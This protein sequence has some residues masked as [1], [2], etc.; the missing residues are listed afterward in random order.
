[1]TFDL[2][3]Q[4]SFGFKEESQHS[5]GLIPECLSMPDAEVI[6]YSHF[7]EKDESDLLFKKLSEEIKWRQDKITY[8]GKVIDL[9]RLTAWYGD[10]DKSY[11]YSNI[12]M[13]SDPWTPTLMY[14]KNKIEEV[15]K[16]NFNSV[17]LNL[18]RNGKDGVSWHQDN[19]PEL[20]K[21]PVIGSVS[22]GGTRR[23]QFRHKLRR[24]L[25]KI[26]VDLTHGSLLIMK[27]ETQRYWQH[28]IPKTSKPVE[29]RINLTFRVI[30]EAIKSK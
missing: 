9:P 10:L 29:S 23:F 4:L 24:E 1:M 17:L 12:A 15:A 16:V 27:G 30:Q 11:T 20:G 14:I 26:D 6:F 19:E 21:N 5:G 7:F 18:Y 8:Y 28:Q 25:G 13:R 3:N 22:F 2:E